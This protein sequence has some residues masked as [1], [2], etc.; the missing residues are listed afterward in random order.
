MGWGEEGE[1]V[2]SVW[3][4]AAGRRAA[5][6]PGFRA[7]RN[8]AR[9]REVSTKGDK[10]EKRSRNTLKKMSEKSCD[11]AP[12]NCGNLAFFFLEPSYVLDRNGESVE[13]EVYV[14]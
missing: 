9:T 6:P 1:G 4:E 12:K 13:T 3:E 10:S 11:G 7:E 8:V 2:A 5:T 14:G